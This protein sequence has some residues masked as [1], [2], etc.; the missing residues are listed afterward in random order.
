[1]K[2]DQASPNMPSRGRRSLLG[3]GLLL[4][5]FTASLA[6]CTSDQRE[7]GA[8]VKKVP[9]VASPASQDYDHTK[10]RANVVKST[11][12]QADVV[13]VQPGKLVF[14]A[15]AAG[16]IAKQWP[17]GAPVVG[18]RKRASGTGNNPFGYLRKVKAITTV[19]DKVV[20][21]TDPATIQDVIVGD[22]SLTADPHVAI[23]IDTT[24]VDMKQYFPD[25]PAGAP[26]PLPPGVVVADGGAHVH[27]YEPAGSQSRAPLPWPRGRNSK[28]DGPIGVAQQASFG[29]F[30]SGAWSDVE[31]GAS[32]LGDAAGDLASSAASVAA[33][34]PGLSY[35]VDYSAFFD[36]GP[37]SMTIFDLSKG[38]S[39]TYTNKKGHAVTVNFTGTGTM[40][41]TVT[42]SPTFHLGATVGLAGLQQ[43]EASATGDFT[44]QL[45]LDVTTN[46]TVASGTDPADAVDLETLLADGPEVGTADPILLLRSQPI[47]G[48][49]IA[50]IPTTYV[51]ELWGDCNFG[52]QATMKAHADATLRAPGAKVGASYSIPV[53]TPEYSFNFTNDAQVSVYGGGG[54][55]VECGLSPRA[56]WLIADAGGPYVGLRGAVRPHGAYVESCA[57][58]AKVSGKPDGQ[59][60]VGVDATV[61]VTIGGNVDAWG[62]V[63]LGV[64]PFSL[65]EL[66]YPDIWGPKTW[67]FPGQG[68]GWCASHCDDEAQD[69]DETGVDCGGA[70]CNPC[71]GGA[72]CA[73]P[74]D[75]TTGFCV[76]GACVD[77]CH[78]LVKDADETDVDCGGPT[79]PR[80]C[81]AGEHCASTSDCGAG[82]CL[83]DLTC[84]DPCSDG[85][86]DFGEVDVDCGGNCAARCAVGKK[87]GTGGDCQTGAC[88]AATGLCIV[89]PCVDGTKD[90]GETDVDCGHVCPNACALAAGC[91]VDADCQ[92]GICSTSGLCVAT[93]CQ[94]GV[95]DGTEIDVDCGGT[96]GLCGN[97]RHCNG[98]GDCQSGICHSYLHI[99][100]ND[101][102]DDGRKD[103][104][105]TGVDCGGPKCSACTLGK[106]CAADGDCGT[107]FCS[108]SGVCVEGACQN[109]VQDPGEVD[110]D[111]GGT[112]P[113][114]CGQGKSC[115]QAKDCL[116]G[117]C[118]ATTGKCIANRC[119]DTVKDGNETDVDCGGSCPTKCATGKGC[120]SAADCASGICNGQTG[121]CAAS[122]CQDGVKDG[123]ETGVDCGGGVCPAC[124]NGGSCVS[125]SDCTGI[126]SPTTKTCVANHCSDLVQDADETG[127]DCGGSLCAGCAA[128]VACNVDHDCASGA[129]GV[130][131]KCA[132]DKCHDGIKDGTETA[133]DCGGACAGCGVGQPCSTGS[134]C[135]SASCSP[136][137][138]TCLAGCTAGADCTSGICNVGKGACV[139]STCQ[140]GVLDGSETAIDCGGG[141]CAGCTVGQACKV[142]SDC[143]SGACEVTTLV[144]V[145]NHCS[146][147]VKDGDESDLDCGGSLCAPCATGLGCAVDTDCQ[148]GACDTS[149]AVC[150]TDHCKDHHK[151]A[152]ETDLDCGGPT[153][154]PCAT[155]LACAVASDCATT[156]C[157]KYT[158]LCVADNC[159][160]GVV[161]DGE[162]DVDCGGGG[163]GPCAVGNG[164]VSSAG[165]TSFDC[166][167]GLCVTPPSEL[168][169]LDHYKEGKT[170]DGAYTIYDREVGE[171]P[172]VYCNMKN[173]G[174]T[175]VWR[176]VS[177]DTTFSD[178]VTFEDSSQDVSNMCASNLN[179]STLADMSPEAHSLVTAGY[180][181]AGMFDLRA[182]TKHIPWTQATFA[183]YENGVRTFGDFQDFLFYSSDLLLDWGVPG[184][185]V[186]QVASGNPTRGVLCRGTTAWT[187]TTWASTICG[188][189][190]V[191]DGNKG[192]ALK[193]GIAYT[194]NNIPAAGVKVY[195]AGIDSVSNY[196][197]WYPF[198]DA[199]DT[200]GGNMTATS[201]AAVVLWVQ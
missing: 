196:Y 43:V 131:N 181:P 156:Y 169:C 45:A 99:C 58:N 109:G 151:D 70:L 96:C 53:W 122:Q 192:W 186:N 124:G 40:T 69:G 61:Q 148:T 132:A 172:P 165:C 155:G 25:T 133:V 39:K 4:A 68:V 160:D 1:M 189:G 9:A 48:P 115:T 92:S 84:G 24:G 152:D 198:V 77:H 135:A 37:G 120:L 138:H 119:L 73:K 47:A 19:G 183:V 3:A 44:A 27:R 182:A 145:A 23:P 97:G 41:G 12:A 178:A 150:I 5:S 101:P 102:C 121:L 153:C 65:Y 91:V 166:K 31:D 197:T 82:A 144:C 147:G 146:D 176:R 141:T 185:V 63:D 127:L 76:G 74:S 86:Q 52:I 118:S 201:G 180:A 26:V 18:N 184:V 94:D 140:D 105:E 159:T 81:G 194:A 67:S 15:S 89:S 130:G 134:D 106:G 161:D 112:C 163:C 111:C 88:N 80:L 7:T 51:M 199:Q 129:C 170:T 64:G 78:N 38:A 123:N 142:G 62:V 16:E 117:I 167:A 90:F 11:Q 21:E 93:R 32:D 36:V 114:A 195:E 136:S 22:A 29:S 54:V 87:C 200:D 30:V 191:Y 149:A 98:D 193:N 108:A 173:G 168:S 158:G 175:L 171:E 46:V 72:A 42:Y 71:A 83:P 75:C 174:W 60:Q 188:G 59:A 137:T 57:P 20:V 110:V 187:T 190:T 10:L 56:S 66:D 104:G 107:G 139:S 157:S 100:T 179:A 162:S 28:K 164:C 85:V 125:D 14:P 49:V 177:N 17:V 35:G 128:G 126:C 34:L 8:I 79:C 113:L 6:G 143:A 154:A 55:A 95:K 50:G 13:D 116:S 103:Q 33:G 2:L